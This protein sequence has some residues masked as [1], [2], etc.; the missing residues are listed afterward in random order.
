MEC[1]TGICGAGGDATGAW[2]TGESREGEGTQAESTAEGGKTSTQESETH[3]TTR[4]GTTAYERALS[5][6]HSSCCRLTCSPTILP[7]LSVSLQN[8]LGK[9]TIVAPRLA[10]P[11]ISIRTHP[12]RSSSTA[13]RTT[14]R[15]STDLRSP[16]H[17]PHFGRR[18]HC[19]TSVCSVD[20]HTDS[21]IVQPWNASCAWPSAVKHA[22]L[23]TQARS[24]SILR[25][26]QNCDLNKPT[27]NLCAWVVTHPQLPP[28]P[29]ARLHPLRSRSADFQ[30]HRPRADRPAI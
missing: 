12:P 13:T 11:A 14:R 6:E 19:F 15:R 3:T 16:R 24:K 30:P 22:R 27:K 7:L 23:A 26:E 29:H 21:F 17:P 1:G 2:G 20:A 18:A 25:V 8:I 10:A 28:D 9:A 5:N 4:N